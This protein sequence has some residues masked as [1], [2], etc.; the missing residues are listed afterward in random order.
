MQL[1]KVSDLETKQNLQAQEYSENSIVK[2]NNDLNLKQHPTLYSQVL[3]FVIG[4]GLVCGCNTDDETV[5]LIS[6]EVTNYLKKY[7][8]KK[9]SFNDFK[10]MT[11]SEI[12]KNDVN[13][14]S[15]QLFIKNFELAAKNNPDR[16]SSIPDEKPPQEQPLPKVDYAQYYKYYYQQFLE[17][18]LNDMLIEYSLPNLY[19]YL[20]KMGKIALTE[21]QKEMILGEK[22]ISEEEAAIALQTIDRTKMFQ[23]NVNKGLL[24]LDFFER[25]KE[26]EN[27]S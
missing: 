15:V 2:F 10:E 5:K 20:V 14:L 3:Q 6:K 9:T 11:K 7:I 27:K 16:K 26:E 1:A 19:P 12:F 21:K 18:K 4:I 23:F 24:V 13:K 17:N 8:G 22:Y 25:R